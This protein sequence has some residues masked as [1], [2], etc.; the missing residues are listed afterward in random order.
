[1]R[2]AKKAFEFGKNKNVFGLASEAAGR[3]HKRSQ[4]NER[5]LN[6]GCSVA[7]L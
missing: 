5:F 2:Y 7:Y 4:L 1:M 3:L 6:V